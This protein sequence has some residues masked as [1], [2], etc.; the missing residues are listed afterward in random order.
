VVLIIVSLAL[1]IYFNY[2]QKN[3][4]QNHIPVATPLYEETTHIP[5]ANYYGRPHS[6]R[7][8]GS[9]WN[10]LTGGNG[11]WSGLTTGGLMGYL[12]GS[13]RNSRRRNTQRN[14]HRW[15]SHSSSSSF[16]GFGR[17]NGTKKTK[18]GYAKTKRR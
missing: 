9:F 17:N 6:R 12:G 15:S 8:R 5:T 14:N 16:M 13:S 10:R 18:S 11:F 7:R 3:R 1:W 4:N 2:N